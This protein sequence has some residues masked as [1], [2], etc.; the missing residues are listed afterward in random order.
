MLRRRAAAGVQTPQLVQLGEQ[1]AVG[2]VDEFL[3]RAV[4]LGR[5]KVGEGDVEISLAGR[6]IGAGQCD[7]AHVGVAAHKPG[8]QVGGL[9]GDKDE[10][11]HVLAVPANG[12]FRAEEQVHEHGVLLGSEV[13]RRGG[14]PAREVEHAGDGA[15]FFL[16]EP[17]REGRAHEQGVVDE[18]VGG[19]GLLAA[20]RVGAGVQGVGLGGEA[21]RLALGRLGERAHL[22]GAE[23]VVHAPQRIHV[24]EPVGTCAVRC[25]EQLRQDVGEGKEL[26]L[27]FAVPRVE[28]GHVALQ[29]EERLDADEVLQLALPGRHVH[30]ATPSRGSFGAGRGCRWISPGR[31]T[32]RSAPSAVSA[33]PHDTGF[34]VP[35]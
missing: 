21:L 12:V 1:H 6:A 22:A 24:E 28:V 14:E 3:A 9:V 4:E 23:G 19:K 33:S 20:R 29:H 13:L 5:G 26:G 25:G 27:P 32:P 17:P 8:G 18:A 10:G 16:S 11:V 2:G 15:G 31:R 34:P 35:D 7:D 30:G